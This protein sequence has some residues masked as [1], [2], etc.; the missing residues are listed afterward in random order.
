MSEENEITAQYVMLQLAILKDEILKGVEDKIKKVIQEELNTFRTEIH[1]KLEKLETEQQKFT[2]DKIAELEEIHRI[3]EDALSKRIDELENQCKLLVTKCDNLLQRDVAAEDRQR[4][5][6]VVVSNYKSDTNISCEENAER[7]FTE[8]LLIP[9]DQVKKF[10]YRNVHY[11][12]RELP[13]QGRSFIVAFLRQ[14]DRDLVMSYAKNLR[15]TDISLKPNYSP[16]TRAKKDEM[17]K[18][19]TSLQNEGLKMRVVERAYQPMLQVQSS[20]G[21]WSQYDAE[22]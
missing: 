3:K 12:G 16:E 11:L 13:N 6:N 1:D 19:K 10:L 18:M 5:T 4:R 9:Q 20:N 2:N 8:K 21:K 14:T 17:L 15:G 22:Y 7:F